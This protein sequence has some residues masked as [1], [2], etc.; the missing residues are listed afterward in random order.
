ML[1]HGDSAQAEQLARG[2]LEASRVVEARGGRRTTH[3]GVASSRPGGE[4]A[5]A[6]RRGAGD[7]A[8]LAD[9]RGLADVHCAL[10]LTMLL[11]GDVDAAQRHVAAALSIRTTWA[12]APRLKSM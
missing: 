4:S 2:A 11:L 8:S 1:E 3:A 5:R 12:D 10:G 6:A 9:V 7:L